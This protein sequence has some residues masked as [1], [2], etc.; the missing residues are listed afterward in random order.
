V[1]DGR[2]LTPLAKSDT[3]RQPDGYHVDAHG[4]RWAFYGVYVSSEGQMVPGSVRYGR[5]V[6]V[7]FSDT[8]PGP[9][10]P[11]RF[12]RFDLQ[13][14]WWAGEPAEWFARAVTFGHPRELI[15]AAEAAGQPFRRPKVFSGAG[16]GAPTGPA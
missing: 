3:T 15:A 14:R 16:V 13:S 4:T 2:T 10:Q 6:G 5:C 7:V 8:S 12:T 9:R 1:T 11:R